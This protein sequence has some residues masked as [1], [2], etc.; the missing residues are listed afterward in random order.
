MS[1]FSHLFNH[2][3]ISIKHSLTSSDYRLL[4]LA[5]AC[6]LQFR[7][8]FFTYVQFFLLPLAFVCLR[9]RFST[10]PLG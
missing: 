6:F 7:L 8:M 9:L 2:L 4:Y 10:T 5:S 3:E 1:Y